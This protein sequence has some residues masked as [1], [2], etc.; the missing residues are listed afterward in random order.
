MDAMT[1]LSPDL[2]A[3]QPELPVKM[4]T[5]FDRIERVLHWVNAL[6]FLVLI[7]TAGMLYLPF[8][9][10]LVGRRGFVRDIHVISGLML[11][12]PVLIALAGPWSRNLKADLRRLNR[13][14]KD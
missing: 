11:P 4:L 7:V 10:T 2:L 12:F 6:L 5:R 9:A 14:M 1:N 3:A 13:W 8:L